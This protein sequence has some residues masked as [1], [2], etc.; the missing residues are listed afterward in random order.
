[1]ELLRKCWWRKPK[2]IEKNRPYW[3]RANSW[4]KSFVMPIMAEARVLVA[5]MKDMLRIVINFGVM[6]VECFMTTITSWV[7]DENVN[8]C[9][10]ECD[11]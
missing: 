10:D 8:E 5:N 6:T 2:Q 1:M 11:C 7:V 9:L 4:T 3:A